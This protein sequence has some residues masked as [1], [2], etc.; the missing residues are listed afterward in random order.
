MGWA[1]LGR[2]LPVLPTA[3]NRDRDPPTAPVR[4]LPPSYTEEWLSLAPGS[5]PPLAK[6]SRSF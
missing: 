4:T 5:V 2:A 3:G 1:G 6:G